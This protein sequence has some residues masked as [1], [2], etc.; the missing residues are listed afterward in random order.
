M[1]IDGVLTWDD[2]FDYAVLS[3]N[4]GW[5]RKRGIEKRNKVS[6]EAC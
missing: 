1:H 6:I 2:F 5:K 3:D 4:E